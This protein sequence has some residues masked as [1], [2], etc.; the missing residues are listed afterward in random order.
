MQDKDVIELLWK[1]GHFRNPENKDGASAGIGEGDLSTLTLNDV[2]VK[3]AL[4]SYQHFQ[5]PLLDSLAFSE[6]GRPAIADGE[7]GPATDRLFEIPRCGAPDIE[8]ALME[9]T[10]SQ[11]WPAGCLATWPQNHVVTISIDKSTMPAFLA[12]DE[13][14]EK[15]IWP[16]VVAAYAAIGLLLVRHDGDPK[17]N[18][19]ARWGNS[20]LLGGGSTIGLAIVPSSTSC[21]MVIWCRYL[22]TYN[23]PDSEHISLW[24]HEIG[25]NMRLGHTS[26]G[27]GVMSPYIVAGLPG[28]WIGDPSFPILKKFFGGEPVSP[29]DTG[30]G[31]VPVPPTGTSPFK[32]L[33]VTDEST[34]KKYRLF[35]Q[36][37]V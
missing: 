10:G 25:H 4:R 23:P 26:G 6:H 30:P 24:L 19:Q 31:P 13:R 29:P 3:E 36:A 15:R 20:S 22:N 27:A 9:A 16:K 5:K 7:S 2:A 14:F 17:S 37:S 11:S 18:L 34:G 32:T 21:Q 33:L 12:A 35:E 8:P 1:Y 28:S